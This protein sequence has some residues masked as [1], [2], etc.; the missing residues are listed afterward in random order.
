MNTPHLPAGRSS[1]AS[2]ACRVLAG[3]A[4]AVALW[5]GEPLFAIDPLPPE[6]ERASLEVQKVYRERLAREGMEE[7]SVVAKRRY[8][9]RMRFQEKLV[10]GLRREAA[11]R[12][13]AIY[14]Q[15]DSQVVAAETNIPAPQAFFGKLPLLCVLGVLGYLVS[16]RVIKGLWYG[17]SPSLARRR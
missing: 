12:E 1:L 13:D 15:I 5:P 17:G 6:I 8:D 16:S 10:A 9:E 2:R 7:K 14:S 4:F 3:A 11:A